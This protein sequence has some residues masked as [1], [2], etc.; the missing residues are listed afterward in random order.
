M[1]KEFLDG[2]YFF[3]LL[4]YSVGHLFSPGGCSN[5]CFKEKRTNSLNHQKTKTTVGPY[6]L[7]TM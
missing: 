2:Y 5:I 7:L 1:L 3:V 6:K 4:S